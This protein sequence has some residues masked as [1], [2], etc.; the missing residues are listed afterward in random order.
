MLAHMLILHQ[1]SCYVV[2]PLGE[3]RVTREGASSLVDLYKL[4]NF[5]VKLKRIKFELY[6][7][8]LNQTWTRPDL[9]LY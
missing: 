4:S 9:D 5:R 2:N 6:T 7:S 1:I 8:I 3:G